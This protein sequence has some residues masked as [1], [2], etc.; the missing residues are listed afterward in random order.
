MCWISVELDGEDS[1]FS[2][3]ETGRLLKYDM[4]LLWPLTVFSLS[5]YRGRK[6]EAKIHPLWQY[7]LCKMT[8]RFTESGSFGK[9]I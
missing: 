9:R 7:Y 2:H 3:S 5:K 6:G 8:A 1:T 4:D